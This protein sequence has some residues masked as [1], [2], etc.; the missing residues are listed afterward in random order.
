VPVVSAVGH[1]VDVTLVDFAADARAAT[2]SQAAE[3]IVP[4][5][6][7]RG[8]SLRQ[9]RARLIHA[10]RARLSGERVKLHAIERK[11]GDPRLAIASQQQRLDERVERL[12]AWS[13]RAIGTRREKLARIEQALNARHP[14]LVI[15]RERSAIVR[16]SDAMRGAMLAQMARRR[17]SLEKAGA[18][19]DALSPLKVLGRGYAIATREDGRAIRS[20]GDVKRGDRITVR[21][22][23]ARI[24]ADVT[25]VT[26]GASALRAAR[27]APEEEK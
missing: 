24:E 15:A 21:V 27:S 22:E 10:I 25:G 16:A 26:D 5:R 18:R 2:P 8:A 23:S 12:A 1:E 13:R 20:A 3:M 11:I 4:D 9:T 14:K 7:A 6:Q 17:A 19:L